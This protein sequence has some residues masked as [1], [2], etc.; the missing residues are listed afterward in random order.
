[1]CR[2]KVV[3][4][5]VFTGA[6]GGGDTVELESVSSCCHLSPFDHLVLDLKPCYLISKPGHNTRTMS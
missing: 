3:S 6:G 1:M 4:Y 5:A 2:T